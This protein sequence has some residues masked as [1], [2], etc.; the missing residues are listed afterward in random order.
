[1]IHMSLSADRIQFG[2]GGMKAPESSPVQVLVA[3]LA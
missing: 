3:H 2:E 1:M